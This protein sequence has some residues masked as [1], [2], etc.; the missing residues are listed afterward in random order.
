MVAHGT[1]AFDTL[2]TSDQ[3]NTGTE[4]S[5]DTSYL[6]NGSA[7]SWALYNGDTSGGAVLDSFNISTITDSDTGDFRTNFTNSMSNGNYSSV[8][9][10]R[11]YHVNS[12]SDDDKTTTGEKHES[13]YISGTSGQRTSYD[14]A[15][16]ALLYHGDLA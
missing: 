14:L 12:H 9:M 15:R 6:Y 7:K 8:G 1:I 4:K 16:N 5:I 2:T 3:V 11:V 13:Y 10:S